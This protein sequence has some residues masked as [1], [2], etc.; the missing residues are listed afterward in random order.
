MSQEASAHSVDMTE[1][2]TPARIRE[3]HEALVSTHGPA[4]R[5]GEHGTADA[6][7]GGGDSDDTAPNGDDSVDDTVQDGDDGPTFRFE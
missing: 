7:P 2:W 6:D 3:L 1:E 5:D 4:E